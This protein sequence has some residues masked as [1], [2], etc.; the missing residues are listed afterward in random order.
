MEPFDESGMTFGPYADGCCFRIEQSK[1]YQAVQNNMKMVEFLLVRNQEGQPPCVWLVEAK[2][3]APRPQTIPDFGVF[4]N[5]IKDKLVNGFGLGVASILKRHSK[6]V[7]EVPETFQN[8]DLAATGF[9]LVLI[10]NG[11]PKAGLPPLQSALQKALQV[12]VR[13]WALGPTA[14]TVLN[15]D[16]AKSH[17]LTSAP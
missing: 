13:T 3:S 17:G 9:R 2:K 1:T 15:Q 12:H 16:G 5:E 6:T 8:L 7:G 14:V 4:I 11:H 10:I